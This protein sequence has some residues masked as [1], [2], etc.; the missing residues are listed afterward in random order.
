MPAQQLKTWS[1]YEQTK[2]RLVESWSRVFLVQWVNHN[3]EA[4]IK[5][6]IKKS[7]RNKKT[8]P[9]NS[10][11]WNKTIRFWNNNDNSYFNNFDNFLSPGLSA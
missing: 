2:I 3:F 11:I 5:Y 9:D 7:F 4:V 1:K 10:L 6:V 8:L